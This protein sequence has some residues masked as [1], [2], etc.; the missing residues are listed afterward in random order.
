M[1]SQSNNCPLCHREMSKKKGFCV[2]CRNVIRRKRESEILYE[3][4][5]L[6]SKVRKENEMEERWRQTFSQY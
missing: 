2:P 1:E 4:R 3:E 5:L 6:L